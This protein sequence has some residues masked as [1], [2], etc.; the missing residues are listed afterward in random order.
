MQLASGHLFPYQVYSQIILTQPTPD[1]RPCIR[2]ETYLH[3]P[4]K[5]PGYLM[6]KTDNSSVTPTIEWPTMATIVPRPGR[7]VARRVEG[8]WPRL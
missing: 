6:S 7:E 2:N 1:R 3:L 5:L 4:G 8:A